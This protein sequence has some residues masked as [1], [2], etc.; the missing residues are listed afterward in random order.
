MRPLCISPNWVFGFALRWGREN[1][2]DPRSKFPRRKSI[3]TLFPSPSRLTLC[4]RNNDETQGKRRYRKIKIQ[5]QSVK[6]TLMWSQLDSPNRIYL[7][8]T[9]CCGTCTTT[10]NRIIKLWFFNLSN[11]SAL[12]KSLSNNQSS[13]NNIDSVAFPLFQRSEIPIRQRP[14][15][16]IHVG[17][18][19]TGSTSIQK[20]MGD[21]K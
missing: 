9:P 12:I 4:T 14:L 21:S 3:P 17:P 13:D 7:C 8:R 15:V 2:W 5:Q 19:K 20:F 18:Q 6:A 1:I 10:Q 11:V 16:V